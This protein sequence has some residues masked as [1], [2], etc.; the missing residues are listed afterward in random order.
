MFLKTFRGS[1]ALTA[2]AL[3]LAFLYGG[4]EMLALAAILG[5][6]EVSLSFDNAVVNATILKTLNMFWQKVFLTA[7]IVIAVI[8]MRLTVPM[9]L[10]CVTAHLSQRREMQIP[11]AQAPALQR[12]SPRNA[13]HCIPLAT[14]LDPRH[15]REHRGRVPFD[16]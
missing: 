5:V 1:F 12:G 9:P 4:T 2:V 14:Q 11:T 10:V 3:V 6:M 8:G 7:G 15:L 13:T 16:T